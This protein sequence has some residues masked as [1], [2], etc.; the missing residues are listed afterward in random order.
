VVHA[1]DVFHV[2]ALICFVYH[3]RFIWQFAEPQWMGAAT[4]ADAS[5]GTHAVATRHAPRHESD[6]R[7]FGP[8][9]SLLPATP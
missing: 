2:M 1:H 4:P 8:V 7:R 9:A 3:F 5:A 6:D